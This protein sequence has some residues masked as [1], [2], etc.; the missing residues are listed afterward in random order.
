MS[1]RLLLVVL[2]LTPVH[3][4][5]P[6]HIWIWLIAQELCKMHHFHYLREIFGFSVVQ[7]RKQPN[8]LLHIKLMV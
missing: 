6:S 1:P 3:R 8:C 5:P 2:E 4:G 7:L